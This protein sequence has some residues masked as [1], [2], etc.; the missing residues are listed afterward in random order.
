MNK[1][2]L[3]NYPL[4]G[5]KTE[6]ND[7]E[8]QEVTDIRIE[9]PL[10]SSAKLHLTQNV[11]HGLDVVVNGLVQPTLNLIYEGYELHVE[12][13]DPTHTRYWAEVRK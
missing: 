12:H 5:V 8:M 1:I 6:I 11:T 13:V 7:V 9:V 4:Y 2:R 10:G 3:S